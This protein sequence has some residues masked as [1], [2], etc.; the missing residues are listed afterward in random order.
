LRI[1][2]YD[3]NNEVQVYGKEVKKRTAPALIR[4]IRKASDGNPLEDAEVAG[5]MIE[6]A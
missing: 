4:G 1:V 6:M 3:V 2:D 5:G